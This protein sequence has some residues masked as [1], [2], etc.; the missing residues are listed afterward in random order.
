M[1]RH[2]FIF[3]SQLGVIY[4]HDY[5]AVGIGI[6]KQGVFITVKN[7]KTCIIMVGGPCSFPS[8]V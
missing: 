4:K 5:H 6:N 2:I 8:S 7:C 3:F 1:I